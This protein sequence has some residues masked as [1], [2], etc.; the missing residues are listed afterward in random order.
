MFAGTVVYVNAGTQLAG[1]SSLSGIL[2]PVLIGSFALI[3][4]FPLIAKKIVDGI[5]A[6]KVYA[7][8][9]KPEKFDKI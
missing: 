3:G 7:R 4:I 9:T 2:S 5:K 1:I 8:W 6:R